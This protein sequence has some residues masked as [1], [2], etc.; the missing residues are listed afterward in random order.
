VCSSVEPEEDGR[1]RRHARVEDG[2]CT[3]ASL[4]RQQLVLEDLGVRMRQARVNEV[5][6]FVVLRLN[7]AERDRERPF[8]CFGAR[9][10]EG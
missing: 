6:V 4:E 3:R 10:Y 7:L 9:E 8:R 5:D 2:R 1:D